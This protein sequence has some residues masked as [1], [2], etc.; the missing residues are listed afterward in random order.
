ME[1]GEVEKLRCELLPREISE[2]EGTGDE[3][4]TDSWQ[5][6]AMAIFNMKESIYIR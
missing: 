6:F 5:D 1:L 2:L 3:A 4:G